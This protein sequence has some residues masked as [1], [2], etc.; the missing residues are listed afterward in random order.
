MQSLRRATLV[1][2]LLTAAAI[3]VEPLIHTHPLSQASSSPCAVCVS[4]IG[5]VTHLAPAA[6]SPLVVLCA[7]APVVVFVAIR[8]DATSLP[9][10]APPAA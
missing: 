7:V 5:R 1:F 3:A 10:R 6:T 4:A 2:V 9:S 8:R